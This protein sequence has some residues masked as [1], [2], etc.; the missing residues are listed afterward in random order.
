MNWNDV[1]ISN[2]KEQIGLRGMTQKA[3]ARGAGLSEQTLSDMLNGRRV[4]RA[5]HV[6]RL[7]EA[8]GVKPNDLFGV[9]TDA[10]KAG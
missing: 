8:L 2:I 9:A 6:P 7:A 4:I 1:L 5:E 3:V 10:P